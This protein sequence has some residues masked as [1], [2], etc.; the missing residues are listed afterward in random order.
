MSSDERNVRGV[1]LFHTDQVIAGIDMMDF[2]RH[3]AGKVGQE[4]QAGAAALTP[5]ARAA[6]GPPLHRQCRAA[7]P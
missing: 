2:A 4:V 3:S 6:S 7:L 5:I 1:F